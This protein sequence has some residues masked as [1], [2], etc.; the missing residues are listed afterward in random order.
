MDSSDAVIHNAGDGEGSQIE[1]KQRR[2]QLNQELK[3]QKYDSD[4]QRTTL[5]Q[6][7]RFS[8]PHSI[9]ITNEKNKSI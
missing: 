6:V 4:R 9:Q 3:Q 8:R 7:G 5:G 1:F 2:R